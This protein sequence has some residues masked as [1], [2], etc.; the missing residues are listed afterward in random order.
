M[1]INAIC[2]KCRAAYRMSD[3]Q[4]GKKVRCNQCHEVFVVIEASSRKTAVRGDAPAEARARSNTLAARRGSPAGIA[5]G[6]EKDDRVKPRP[7]KGARSLLPWILGGGMAGVGLVILLCGGIIT[8]FLLRAKTA[9]VAN[10]SPP[11]VTREN[12]PPVQPAIEVPP[13]PAPAV[14]DKDTARKVKQATAYL[15]VRLANGN[16][17]EGSGFFAVQPGLVLT[18]AHVLGMLSPG[19]PMPTEV[20]VMVHSGEPEEFTVPA[21]VRGVDRENDLGV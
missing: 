13:G 17:V 7:K 1:P 12:D 5:R 16:T 14:I 15:Q 21:G 6:E 10:P 2:P 9:E 3:Q 19:S 11:P 18:N 4:E 20:R 8:S